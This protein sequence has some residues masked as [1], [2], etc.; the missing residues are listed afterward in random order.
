MIKLSTQKVKSEWI[1]YNG[2]MNVT[3]YTWAFDVAL[4]E[5]LTDY[6][7]MGKNHIGEN[8]MGPFALQ[9]QFF[10]LSELLE[11]ES[12]YTKI[13]IL[14]YDKKRIHLYAEIVQEKNDTRSATWEGM[15]INVNHVSRKPE[16]YAENIYQKIS[17][18]YKITENDPLPEYASKPFGMRRK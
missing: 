5:M 2:H 13:R 11:G 14:D 17:E 7:G 12:F 8:K 9:S 4:D 18:F 6:L 15:S 1:D 3:Y 16:P 10:Y